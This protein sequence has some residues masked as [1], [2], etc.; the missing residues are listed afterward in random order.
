MNRHVH[1]G[2]HIPVAEHAIEVLLPGNLN[3]PISH[4]QDEISW[5]N[6]V[7]WICCWS[8]VCQFLAIPERAL[9]LVLHLSIAWLILYSLD[10][11]RVQKS[12]F[13]YCLIASGFIL[14]SEYAYCMVLLPKD[15][16]EPKLLSKTVSLLLLFCN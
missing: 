11:L 12:A 7:C 14:F 13:T 4:H 5:E 8:L 3:K 1:N 9:D 10:V 2:D 16:I 6:Y 15:H